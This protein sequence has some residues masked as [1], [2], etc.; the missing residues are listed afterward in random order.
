MQLWDT[1]CGYGIHQ[2]SS[3]RGREF[4]AMT[5]LLPPQPVAVVATNDLALR[6]INVPHNWH[7]P[8][9]LFIITCVGSSTFEHAHFNTHGNF[10]SQ[11]VVR[12]LQ[13]VLVCLSS[14]NLG[15]RLYVILAWPARVVPAS[16]TC[17][18][19]SVPQSHTYAYMFVHLRVC[20]YIYVTNC[21]DVI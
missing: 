3:P 14:L 10:I 11:L 6:Y 17:T 19:T 18:C 13:G 15:G 16:Y 20:M 1:E 4:V 12:A 2:F 8:H 21:N 9:E 5:C 7:E